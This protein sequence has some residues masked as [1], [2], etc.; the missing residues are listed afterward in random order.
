MWL[1]RFENQIPQLC[2]IWFVVVFFRIWVCACCIYF[3]TQYS[4]VATIC[5][6][7][8]Y[9]GDIAGLGE[10]P[11]LKCAMRAANCENVNS[12]DKHL[13]TG[14]SYKIV[15]YPSLTK[16]GHIYICMHQCT[17]VSG[18]PSTTNTH[19]SLYSAAIGGHRTVA[20]VATITVRRGSRYKCRTRRLHERSAAATGRGGRRRKWQCAVSRSAACISK[21]ARIRS[22]NSHITHEVW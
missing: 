17:H 19:T 14:N 7:A 5:S 11:E 1:I 21:L 10:N 12:I 18:Y 2:K 6:E 22:V 16:Y 20:A 15:Q 13:H 9:V 4:S 3:R 8:Q